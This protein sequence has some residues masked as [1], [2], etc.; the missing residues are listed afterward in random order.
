MCWA[1]LG[2]GLGW[3][4]DMVAQRNPTGKRWERVTW[5]FPPMQV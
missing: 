3:V 2:L 5:G 4:S 1:G